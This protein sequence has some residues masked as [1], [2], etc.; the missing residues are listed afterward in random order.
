[1]VTARLAPTTKLHDTK[2]DSLTQKNRRKCD[3]NTDEK[4]TP[5]LDS[6]PPQ[7]NTKLI[8]IISAATAAIASDNC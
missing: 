4:S 8:L 2:Q 5:T 6:A 7:L 1:M 3:I